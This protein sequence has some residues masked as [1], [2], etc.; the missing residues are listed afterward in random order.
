MHTVERWC[1]TTT[2]R[3]YG[4]LGASSG[5]GP[6]AEAP[7]RPCPR[8]FHSGAGDSTAVHVAAVMENDAGAVRELFERLD[9]FVELMRFRNFAIAPAYC[10]PTGWA[11]PGGSDS[12]ADPR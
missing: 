10:W 6:G 2:A 1:Q 9:R 5:G 11:E 3:R 4:I 12:P 7:P 8:P